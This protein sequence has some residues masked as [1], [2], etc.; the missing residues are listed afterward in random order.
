MHN[1]GMLLSDVVT[2]YVNGKPV[3]S[4]LWQSLDGSERSWLAHAMVA[5][6]TKRMEVRI[7]DYDPECRTCFLG[8]NASCESGSGR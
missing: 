7:C 4:E 2:G 8:S 3:D 6:K 1:T 5:A